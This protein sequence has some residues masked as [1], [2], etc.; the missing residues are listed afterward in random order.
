MVHHV[1][2]A[3][4]ELR[5]HSGRDRTSPALGSQASRA[6]R[7]A[8]IAARPAAATNRTLLGVVIFIASES[9]FFLAFV[10]AFIAYREARFATAE[11]TRDLVRTS[12]FSLPHPR[13]T[14]TMV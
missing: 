12:V 7:R 4:R 11:A 10:L 14:A 9:I 5:D 6:A 2:A 8:M 13:I 3:T 1:A